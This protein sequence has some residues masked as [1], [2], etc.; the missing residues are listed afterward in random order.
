MTD[1]SSLQHQASPHQTTPAI[2]KNSPPPQMIHITY[3]RRKAS[4]GGKAHTRNFAPSGV[5]PP[6]GWSRPRWAIQSET[7]K[8]NVW[9]INN[10]IWRPG[11]IIS[12]I[13]RD[14]LRK[15]YE[16]VSKTCSRRIVGALAKA[17]V[18][19]VEPRKEVNYPYNR[20]KAFGVSLGSLTR[21]R[22][23]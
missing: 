13:D 12:I 8:R 2:R 10:K 15:Y 20:R 3:T 4:L 21:R 19:L 23:T 17:Y 18:K 11:A 6:T 7:H 5:F 22:P 9:S 1:F 14:L 16:K